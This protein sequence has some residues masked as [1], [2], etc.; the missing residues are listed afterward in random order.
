MHV[1][2]VTQ[3]WWKGFLQADKK[4]CE[5]ASSLAASPKRHNPVLLT[6][7]PFIQ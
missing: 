4:E 2:V 3:P 7:G 6:W 1:K 5:M